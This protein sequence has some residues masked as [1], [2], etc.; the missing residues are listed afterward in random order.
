MKKITKKLTRKYSRRA[1]ISAPPTPDLWCWIATNPTKTFCD[2]LNESWSFDFRYRS[3]FVRNKPA[4]TLQR[5]KLRSIPTK[6][7]TVLFSAE[8]RVA[9]VA[10][11]P[12]VQC[13]PSAL[14]PRDEVAGRNVDNSHPV[15][16]QEL[17]EPNH[18]LPLRLH[19]VVRNAKPSDN[20]ALT[21][22]CI[23]ACII[24]LSRGLLI[25]LATG[26]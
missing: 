2:T 6:E 16:D 20:S 17:V 11:Q 5:R 18:F 25:I 9:V 7:E 21:S 12:L 22:Y 8:S 19:G 1:N 15:R 26:T 4:G 10:N 24:W 3:P 14:P 23:L 13:L